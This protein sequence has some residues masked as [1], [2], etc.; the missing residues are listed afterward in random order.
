MDIDK[1]ITYIDS[2]IFVLFSLCSFFYLLEFIQSCSNLLKFI[3]IY[4]NLFKFI[5]I[6]ALPHA[7][8]L[9]SKENATFFFLTVTAFFVSDGS[10]G[11]R[12]TYKL[13]Y[14]SSFVKPLSFFVFYRVKTLLILRNLILFVFQNMRFYVHFDPYNNI[15]PEECFIHIFNTHISKENATFYFTLYLQMGRFFVHLYFK[16]RG[17]INYLGDFSPIQ[18]YYTKKELKVPSNYEEK[19]KNKRM[20]FLY[21]KSC[22]CGESFGP[23]LDFYKEG[24]PIDWTIHI[25]KIKELVKVC[26]IKCLNCWAKKY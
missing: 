21:A 2:Y 5:Q 12:N 9:I 25:D 16:N 3:E 4:S 23:C 17:Y 14:F 10:S 1:T 24:K 11:C 8:P 22:S 19:I 7:T 18:V 15:L 13:T 20:K 6:Y 26:E